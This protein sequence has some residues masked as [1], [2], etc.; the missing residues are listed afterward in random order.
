[1]SAPAE[2]VTP[3]AAP[4][5]AAAAAPDAPPA[6][7]TPAELDELAQK[8]FV[9]QLSPSLKEAD[10]KAVF[11]PALQVYVPASPSVCFVAAMY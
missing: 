9:R 3:V 10:V 6:Q 2:A 4:V 5:A 1:M 7:R 8:V 11:E